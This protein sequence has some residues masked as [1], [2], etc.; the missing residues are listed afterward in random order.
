VAGIGRYANE[1]IEALR[2]LA[3][4][5]EVHTAAPGRPPR[6]ERWW[7][8][9]ARAQPGLAA[10]VARA[11]P[12]VLHGLGGDAVAW[13]PLA[14]QVVTVHD[15]VPWTADPPRDPASRAYLAAQ[16]RLLARA[17][18]VIVPGE[19]IAGDVTDVLGV[20]P[21]RVA[22][23]PHGIA[24]RFDATPA[25][26]DVEARRRCGVGDRYLLWVGSLHGP[27]PRKGLDVLFDALASLPPDARPPLALAG[28]A[29]LGSDWARE[30]AERAGVQAI[31]TG[32]VSDAELAALYR[33]ATAAV[34]PSR[35]EG[36]GLPALEALACGTPLVV[37]DAGTLPSVVGDAALVVPA[38]R[39]EPLAE[40]LASLLG[41][42]ARRRRLGQA[43]PRRAGEFSWRRCAERTADV[44]A[45]IASGRPGAGR[46]SA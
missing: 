18:G 28:R 12:A 10:A 32:Y 30:Q 27:D 24:K 46:S 37:T 4:D 5:L 44:Y 19:A 20:A 29:G 25:P 43:G 45:N 36:F 16:R 17:A 7:Y 8:R 3:P 15:V 13:F 22:V 1:L 26:G 23:V 31:L 40:A 6:S 9:Y 34:V 11:R 21:G 42:E 2:G 39:P 14:R 33:G 38:G 41:D 35:H